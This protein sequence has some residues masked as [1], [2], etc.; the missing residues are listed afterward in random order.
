M[1]KNLELGSCSVT[2]IRSV[3]LCISFGSGSGETLPSESSWSAQLPISAGDQQE[4]YQLEYSQ[5]V[6]SDT[7]R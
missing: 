3:C 5:S 7:L 4:D 1:N 6:K 2:E